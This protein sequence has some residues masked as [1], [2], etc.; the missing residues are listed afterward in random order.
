MCALAFTFF[1]SSLQNDITQDH[2]WQAN[3]KSVKERNAAMF[4]NELMADVSFIVGTAP[5]VQRIPA[6]R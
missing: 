5:N 6:H 4:N 1:F 2:D 3:L